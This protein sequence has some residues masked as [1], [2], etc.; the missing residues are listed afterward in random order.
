MIDKVRHFIKINKTP[1][2]C[3]TLSANKLGSV[4]IVKKIGEESKDGVI[5]K[6]CYPLNCKNQIAVK[7]IK[8]R[9]EG[10][11]DKKYAKD[12]LNKDAVNSTTNS[13]WSELLFLTMTTELVQNKICPNLPMYF[14]NKFCEKC[15]GGKYSCLY[16]TNELADGNLREYLKTDNYSLDELM[17]CFYQIFLGLY[18]LKYHFG[19]EHNDLHAGNVLFHNLNRKDKKPEIWR[20]KFDDKFYIDVPIYDKLFV[21]WDF[22]RSTIKGKVEP[23]EIL[24][25]SEDYNTGNLY[26]DYG[27]VV[28]NLISSEYSY[29]DRN[30]AKKNKIFID[31]RNLLNA[32]LT[33]VRKTAKASN[34]PRLM[35][36]LLP[37]YKTG[38]SKI[39]KTFNIEKKYKS[40]DSFVES[41]KVYK[42]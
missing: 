27:H 3:S 13:L 12:F 33:G 10:S 1:D 40:K 23:S 32:L 6:A 28:S 38:K 36:E 35:F 29:T 22:G 26:E 30:K 24:E 31:Y 37:K 14:N 25:I 8:I 20:Y 39:S 42:K 18:A 34:N 4:K 2:D 11:E 19:V 21:I 15:E 41:L 7:K 17:S 16:I 5:Y 9:I